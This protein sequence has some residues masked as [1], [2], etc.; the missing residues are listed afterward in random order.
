MKKFL[1]SFSISIFENHVF[2]KKIDRAV[3]HSDFFEEE[4]FFSDNLCEILGIR[5]KHQQ[6]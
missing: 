3:N 1:C 4:N 6:R 5:Q 2:G